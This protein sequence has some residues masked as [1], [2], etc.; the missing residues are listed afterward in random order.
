MGLSI[1]KEML[2]ASRFLVGTAVGNTYFLQYILGIASMTV[3]IYIA[4]ISPSKL[5]CTLVTINTVCITVGQVIASVVDGIFIE[6]KVNGWRLA[7][8][9]KKLFSLN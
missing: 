9:P 3:P 4:E 7:I 5:R 8:F 2:L 1:N 6:D